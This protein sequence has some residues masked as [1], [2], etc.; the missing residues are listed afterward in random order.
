MWYNSLI[1]KKGKVKKMPE[2]IITITNN[3]EC[4]VCGSDMTR[5]ETDNPHDSS[6]QNYTCQGCGIS[7]T[8]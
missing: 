6:V 4:P 2:K 8:F 1:L 5:D 7:A 3:K